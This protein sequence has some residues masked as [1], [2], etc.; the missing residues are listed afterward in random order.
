MYESIYLTNP[1]TPLSYLPRF[2]GHSF[3]CLII[4]LFIQQA[5][6]GTINEFT[7][8]GATNGMWGLVVVLNLPLT[9]LAL[10]QFRNT[11]W[12]TQTI[13]NILSDYAAF[14]SVLLWTALSA[15]LAGSGLHGLPHHVDSIQPW[16]DPN[17]GVGINEG[18]ADLPVSARL[19]GDSHTLF[20]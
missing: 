12:L 4:I 20:M 5:I 18:M 9:A 17:W 2:F 13:R 3:G 7:E 14:L 15:A 8:Y 10:T 11:Q 6:V 1:S 16:N 19:L